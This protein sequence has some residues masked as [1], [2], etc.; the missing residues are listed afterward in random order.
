MDDEKELQARKGQKIE[1]N[2]MMTPVFQTNS[3]SQTSAIIAKIKPLPPGLIPDTNI[4]LNNKAESKPKVDMYNLAKMQM[5]PPIKS[6]E[7][8]NENDKKE[9][10]EQKDRLIPLQM[11]TTISGQTLM[12]K[13]PESK[14]QTQRS[15]PV[16][17]VAKP[18]EPAVSAMSLLKYI[19][20]SVKCRRI[21][22]E[23]EYLQELI[24]EVEQNS[25]GADLNK[26]VETIKILSEEKAKL[27]EKDFPSGVD[28]TFI[29]A[30]KFLLDSI[31]MFTGGLDHIKTCLEKGNTS[32]MA[33]GKNTIGQAFR[34]MDKYFNIRDE[35]KSKM[36]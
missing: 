5:A 16:A 25:S 4:S 12:Y 15:E 1:I 23:K 29:E 32:E 14:P 17:P 21:I 18:A 22:Y 34:E 13:K 36:V 9:T 3:T 26:I 7:K 30:R 6:K 27:K 20:V 19:S 24:Q 28:N 8:K 11:A 10:T 2:R 35:I 33:R 31:D